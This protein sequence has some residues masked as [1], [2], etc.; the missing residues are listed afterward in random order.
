MQQQYLLNEQFNQYQRQQQYDMPPA[1]MPDQQWVDGQAQ[2]FPPGQQQM[3]NQAN[4]VQIPNQMD[5]RQPVIITQGGKKKKS[6]TGQS[7]LNAIIVTLAVIL[8]VGI[9]ALTIVQCKQKKED[10]D[11]QK[12]KTI[13]QE[14]E[15]SSQK[16]GSS[17]SCE[18]E[19]S[20]TSQ[21]VN[22]DAPNNNLN[23]A[24]QSQNKGPSMGG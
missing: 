11:A 23:T 6:K 12:H 8:I 13:N 16:T 5:N 7:I 2:M 1:P 20:Y 9:I 22:N 4:M 17:N 15:T 14:N 24:N 10:L 19:G 3:S 18:D 21:T